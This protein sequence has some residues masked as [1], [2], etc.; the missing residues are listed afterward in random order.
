MLIDSS[1]PQSVIDAINEAK[2]AQIL[3][4]I[5]K[6]DYKIFQQLFMYVSTISDPDNSNTLTLTKE[7]LT[8]L[9]MN[10]VNG[11]SDEEVLAIQAILQ[12]PNHLVTINN[13]DG[14]Q[15]S[16]LQKVVNALND[17][18]DAEASGALNLTTEDFEILGVKFK[19]GVISDD[20]GFNVENLVELINDSIDR[21]IAL[22]VTTVQII[23]NK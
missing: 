1:T 13:E 22:D 10:D 12:D 3:Q 18:N 21:D 20:N 2:L 9:G 16:N 19:N 8:A 4:V 15:L 14:L 11:F 5:I 23:Y 7:N 6:Q 17:L